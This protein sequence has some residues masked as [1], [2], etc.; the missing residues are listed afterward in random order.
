MIKRSRGELKRL[1]REYLLGNY[2]AVMVAMLLAFLL[3]S[4]LLAPFSAG[5][6][7]EFNA[8]VI[9]YL[10]A[11]V[12]IEILRRL[13]Q[14]GVLRMHLLLARRQKT[15]IGDLF[16]IFRNRPD[17]LILA[18]AL[19][20]AILAVPV[21]AAGVCIYCFLPDG[22]AGRVVFL[23]GVLIAAAAA[24]LYLVYMFELIYPLYLEHPQMTV[25]EGF[26]ESK[27]LMQGNK[28]RLFLLQVSFLGWQLLGL[29]SIG[30]GMFW[31]GPYMTQ[32]TVNFYLDLTGKLDFPDKIPGNPD[33]I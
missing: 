9:M 26:R 3:P 5:L 33:W 2:T 1:A 17:R 28:K 14:T 31:I 30:V 29:C 19:F 25:L 21:L 4:I 8:A 24:E 6:T 27:R 7:M 23:S 11:A 32:T 12:I 22:T 13:L 20:Y 18:T 15:G 10:L 16:W